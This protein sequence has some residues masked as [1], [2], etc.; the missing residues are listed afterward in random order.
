[1]KKQSILIAVFGFTCWSNYIHAQYNM[2]SIH[3]DFV[4]KERREKFDKYLL[5]N[6]IE[7]TF[8]G[9]LD[10]DTEFDFESSCLSAIQ[11]QIKNETVLKGLNKMVANYNT[12]SGSTKRALLSAIYSL[13]P[14]D[15]V[16]VMR[17]FLKRETNPKLFSIAAVYL[18]RL[19]G[20]MNFTQNVKNEERK[21]GGYDTLPI[22]HELNKY[23]SSHDRMTFQPHPALS[24]L[25]EW[26]KGG[27]IKTVY[28]FQRWNRNYPGMAVVQLEDGSFARDSSGKLLTFRQLARA[29]TN[30]PYF[31]T[32]GNTPQGIFSINGTGVSRNLIIGPTPNLQT[33]LPF[34]MESQFWFRGYDSTEDPLDNYKNLLPGSWQN[35]SPIFESFYAGKCGRSEIIVHGVTID[36]KYF[37][38]EPFYPLAPTDGCLCA[39]ELWNEEDG[40]LNQSEQLRLVNTFNRTPE[41]RGFLFV[42][43]LNN[44]SKAVTSEEIEL[45]V[46]QFENSQK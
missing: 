37:K 17:L 8:N 12:L 7:E 42:I 33:I 32:N 4:K 35:Y 3:T 30:L 11:F 28:S 6:T 38:N 43:N 24:Q 40:T 23:I 5:N 45:L 36:P 31:I 13:Y 25:F 34:E 22:L 1:M 18:Y 16:A 41:R 14:N 21:I 2:K 20:S 46:N 10:E 44:A 26:E 27:H 39:P 9:D 15:F 19:D 29:G